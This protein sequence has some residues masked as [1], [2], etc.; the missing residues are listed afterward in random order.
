MLLLSQL[1]RAVE[2]RDNKRPTLADLRDSGAIEQDADTIMFLYREAYYLQREK[3]ESFNR[4]LE[5]EADLAACIHKAEVEI[6]KQRNGRIQTVELFV[7]L[8][9]SAVRNAAKAGYADVR[10]GV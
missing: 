10:S 7:D 3:P 6:A 5:R 4:Q 1:N 8:Q 2:G 9:Y